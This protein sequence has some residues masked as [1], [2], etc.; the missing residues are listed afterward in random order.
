MLRGLNTD[1]EWQ[2]L[3]YHVQTEDWGETNPF[4]VTRIFRGG[5]VVCTIKTNYKTWVTLD[6]KARSSRLKTVLEDQHIES[7]KNIKNGS[8]S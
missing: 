7:V 8:W 1:L 4:L 2:G 5:Q 3:T 6:L